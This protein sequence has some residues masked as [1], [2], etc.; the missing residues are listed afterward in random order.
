MISRILTIALTFC[1]LAA[2]QGPLTI[3][4][5]RAFL[6]SSIQMKQS[7]KDIADYLRTVKL[8]ERLDDSVLEELQKG[9]GPKS[10]AVLK[11]LRDAS[12]SLKP[13]AP[14]GPAPPPPRLPPPPA[15]GEL[16]KII[17]EARENS[18]NYSDGLPNFICLQVT[19]RYHNAENRGETSNAD[20]ITERLTY[21]NHK[22]EYKMVTHNDQV[23]NVSA[24]KLGGSLSRGEFGSLLREIFDPRSAT[25]FEWERWT[26]HNKRWWYVFSFRVPLE[27]SQY[28]IHSGQAKE[29][30]V[31]TVGFSGSI[32]IDK[33]TNMVMRVKMQADNIP[34]TFPMLAASQQL[35]YDFQ[36]IGDQEFLLP[37]ISEMKMKLDA[38]YSTRN[39]IEFRNYNKYSAD[40]IIKFDEA[41][42]A[43]PPP[44][45]D[46]KSKEQPPK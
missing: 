25:K 19:R 42:P 7:D 39:V 1:L 26:G 17:T 12:A 41:P 38:R 13:P 9:L 2:A 18:L 36:K 15:A 34:P 11:N 27:T 23:T 4:K 40:T 33:E 20:T 28:T 5:L 14:E 31:I 30:Q 21:Y 46:D 32:F 43:T 24:E 3:Q 6:K 29:E 37:L 35:D 22:E 44:L 16:A 45:G 10:I 8:S